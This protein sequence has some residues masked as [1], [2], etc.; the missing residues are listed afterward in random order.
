LLEQIQ[1]KRPNQF[2][3][4]DC[5]LCGSNY[6]ALQV[7]GEIE[8]AFNRCYYYS[9]HEPLGFDKKR[10]GLFLIEITSKEQFDELFKEDGLHYSP[11]DDKE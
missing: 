7:S 10:D 1:L 4:I 3:F 2:A 11:P 8:E 9:G 5:V 6:E